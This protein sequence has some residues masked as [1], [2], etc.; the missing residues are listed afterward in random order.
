MSGLYNLKS[1]VATM[2]DIVAPESSDISTTVQLL[3]DDGAIT[4]QN[5][6]VI[7]SKAGASAIT[8]GIPTTA[9][10]GTEI[11][12]VSISAQAHTVT[13]ATIGFNA[14][15]AASDVATFGG[16]IADGFTV[17]AYG[18]EWYTTANTNVTLG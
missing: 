12:I 18:G 5:G 9:Q 2:D 10:N 6:T 7:L 17:V 14:G 11:V 15:N 8:L 4:I 16:A 1:G 13:A 3:A